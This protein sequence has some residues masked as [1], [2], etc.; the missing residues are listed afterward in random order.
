MAMRTSRGRLEHLPGT[1]ERLFSVV[2]PAAGAQ[3]AK[4]QNM[5]SDVTSG[6]HLRV[7]VMAELLCAR[8]L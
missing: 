6:C 3:E 1:N 2:A 8:V 4:Y 5:G 7:G